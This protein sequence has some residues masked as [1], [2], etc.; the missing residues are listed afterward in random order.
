MNKP[1]VVRSSGLMPTSVIEKRGK[2]LLHGGIAN[3][4]IHNHGIY[5]SRIQATETPW[6]ALLS[7]LVDSHP[8]GV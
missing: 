7:G 8:G 5:A 2:K 4:V 6:I 3:N 1:D